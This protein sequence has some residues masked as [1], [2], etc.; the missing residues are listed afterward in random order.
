MR[1]SEEFWT[2]LKQQ[3]GSAQTISDYTGIKLSTVYWNLKKYKIS[4]G[5]KADTARRLSTISDA[6]IIAKYTEL[7]SLI[8]L[9]EF[10]SIRGETL[11]SRIPQE[12]LRGNRC[13][14]ITCNEIFFSYDN[15][16]SFYYAGFMAADGCIKLK[17]GKYKQIQLALSAADINIVKRFAEHILYEGDVKEY[18]LNSRHADGSPIK[19]ADLQISSDRMFDDLHRFGLTVRK[20]HTFSMPQWL[21]EHPLV[22]HF[23]RGYFDGDGSAFISKPS[24][25]RTI[26]QVYFS[27][28]GTEAFLTQMRNLFDA[29]IQ[30]SRFKRIK[31]IRFNGGIGVLE[32]GGNGSALAIADYLYRDATV[33]MERKRAKF[34]EARRFIENAAEAR[35]SARC[36]RPNIK[37]RRPIIAINISTGARLALNGAPEAVEKLGVARSGITDCLSGRQNQHRG[38]TFRYADATNTFSQ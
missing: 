33:W 28:R 8:K 27:T 34:E 5:P 38:W 16:L 23:L 30:S 22:H 6:E 31:K 14:K 9:G 1:H 19:R 29:N 37:H 10:Y 11:R 20:T 17:D 3:Y 18:S 15:E 24:G 32:Y 13:S 25:T 36:G 26:P 2:I 4:S 12:L 7:N 21:I 35:S